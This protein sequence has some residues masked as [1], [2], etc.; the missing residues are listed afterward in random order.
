MKKFL[1]I[2]FSLLILLSVTH[3]T[4][5]THYCGGEIAASKV[6]ISGELATCGMEDADNQCSLP[7]KHIGNHCCDDKVSVLAVDP[8]YAPSF[9]CF[10]A[11]SQNILLVFILPPSSTILPLSTNNLNRKDACPPGYFLVSAVSLPKICVFRI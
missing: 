9:N 4:I 7:G 10:K 5:A 11:F 6:S 1:S 8:D 3:F 2:S